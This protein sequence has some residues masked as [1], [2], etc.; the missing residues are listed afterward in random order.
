MRNE[1]IEINGKEYS[2]FLSIGAM[3]ELENEFGENW[4]DDIFSKTN[5]Y[6]KLFKV[7]SILSRHGELARRR[8]GYDP[9]E[10]LTEEMLNTECIPAELYALGQ[11]V[12]NAILK[13]YGREIEDKAEKDVGLA[14]LNKKKVSR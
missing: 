14:E 4:N 11:V 1:T 9:A 8:D 6:E 2:L 3:F 10:T 5:N 13:G 7:A 12:T